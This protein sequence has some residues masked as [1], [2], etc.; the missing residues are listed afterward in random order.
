MNHKQ[1]GDLLLVAIC[2]V[3][4]SATIKAQDS[5]VVAQREHGVEFYLRGDKGSAYLALQEA[6]KLKQDDAE[7]WYYLGLLD[8]G[9]GNLKKALSAF[10]KAISF[11]STLAP[12]HRGLAFSLLREHKNLEEAGESVSSGNSAAEL[13]YMRAVAQIQSGETAKAVSSADKALEFDQR[14]APALLV[15]ALALSGTYAWA[16]AS[17]KNES[18]SDRAARMRSTLGILSRYS[19]LR[20]KSPL[21]E[22]LRDFLDNVQSIANDPD[23]FKLAPIGPPIYDSP[24]QVAEKAEPAYTDKARE[25]HRT[26]TVILR[27]VFAADGKVKMIRVISG[28]PDGLTERAIEAARKIKFTPATK[29]GVNV[30]MWMELQYNFN[31]D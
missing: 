13:Y 20:A 14:F 10:E 4:F 5:L 29:D 11:D 18:T 15:K 17:P 27:A 12:A 26:G 8:Y 21:P 2:L 3:G 23:V 24:S 19:A 9:D 6:L 7:T 31:L 25:K 22:I 16:V 30:S 1:V 28:M